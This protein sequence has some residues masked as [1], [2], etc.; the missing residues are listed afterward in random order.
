M[1]VFCLYELLSVIFGEMDGELKLIDYESLG[2]K[3]D[4]IKSSVL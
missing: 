3:C 1:G 4:E 2:A